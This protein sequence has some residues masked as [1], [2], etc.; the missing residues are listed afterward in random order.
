V[1]LDVVSETEVNARV[2]VVVPEHGGNP[3]DGPRLNG[4]YEPESDPDHCLA[5]S[6][7]SFSVSEDDFSGDV[8]HLRATRPCGDP[9]AAI[10]SD[11]S[12]TPNGPVW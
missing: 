5:G 10:T 7:L 12:E 1:R 4:S 3:A 2:Q 9:L 11:G 6:S 8:Y